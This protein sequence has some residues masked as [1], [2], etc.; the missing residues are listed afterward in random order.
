[1]RFFANGKELLTKDE[2]DSANLG[3]NL[4]K[5]SE[6]NDTTSYAWDTTQ[7]NAKVWWSKTSL[8]VLNGDVLQYIP[9]QPNTTYSFSF[10]LD[11]LDVATIETGFYFVEQQSQGTNTKV[12][13]DNQYTWNNHQIQN[14]GGFHSTTFTTQ[15]DCHLLQMHIRYKGTSPN[16]FILEKVKLEEGSNATAWTPNPNDAEMIRIWE[17]I[18]ALKSKVGG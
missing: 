9:V 17:Q 7:G 18:N 10:K 14:T 16:G 4:I 13:K 3:I 2:Y 5:G 8:Q 1:M 15:A 11:F 12:Y 6:L